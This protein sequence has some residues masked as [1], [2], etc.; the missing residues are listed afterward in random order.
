MGKKQWFAVLGGLLTFVGTVC[1]VISEVIKN[2]EPSK[3]YVVIEATAD[4][5]DKE[6]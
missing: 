1:T 2:K 5:P 4:E 3:D 6:S